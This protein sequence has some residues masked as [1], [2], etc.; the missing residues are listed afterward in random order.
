[1]KRSGSCGFNLI[2]MGRWRLAETGMAASAII[3]M[4]AVKVSLL[5]NGASLKSIRR[6]LPTER[7]SRGRVICLRLP[8]E[9]ETHRTAAGRAAGDVQP[10]VVSR[11]LNQ[12]LGGRTAR[13]FKPSHATHKLMRA[14]RLPLKA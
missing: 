9:S 5:C 4:A 6:V 8:G 10:R 13:L 12:S 14:M 3:M 7:H 2:E 11:R 1:M